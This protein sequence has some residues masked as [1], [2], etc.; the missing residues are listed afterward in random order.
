M[1][2]MTAPRSVFTRSRA[3]TNWLEKSVSPWLG[4]TALRRT[5]PVVSSIWLSTASSAPWPRSVL[6][7][8]SQAST[9]R[10]SWLAMPAI[11]GWSW[12]AA[13]VNTTAM[14]WSWVITTSPLGSEACTMLPGSTRRRPTRPEM[15]AVIRLYVRLRRALATWASSVLIVPSSWLTV[16]AWVSSCWRAMESSDMSTWYRLR[17]RR[18]FLSVASSLASCPSTCWTWTRNGRGSICASTAPCRTSCPSWY[19]TLTSWP[20]TRL[21]T[22]TVLMAVTEPSPSRYTAMSPVRAGRATT[23]T[24]RLSPRPARSL[25]GGPPWPRRSSTRTT[26]SRRAP[27]IKK[28]RRR[29]LRRAASSSPSPAGSVTAGEGMTGVSRV[30]FALGLRSWWSPPPLR[31]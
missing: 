10:R 6:R 30:I 18:A 27:A 22:V 2:T 26:A 4:K 8:R 11:T 15:G 14:G 29:R 7:S 19:D 12:S 24:T 21:R 1:G 25:G 23:G 13:M 31:S 16:A 9:R 20:S 17:S 28:R 5:V 3:F